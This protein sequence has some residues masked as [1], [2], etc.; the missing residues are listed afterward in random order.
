MATNKRIW[1]SKKVTKGMGLGLWFKV[2]Y[3]FLG[4]DDKEY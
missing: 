4:F 3:F 2:E 1:N